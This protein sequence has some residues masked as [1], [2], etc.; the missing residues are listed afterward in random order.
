M[1]PED[2]VANDVRDIGGDGVV[3]IQQ[4]N[5]DVHE[6]RKEEQALIKH[7]CAGVLDEQ[8]QDALYKAATELAKKLAQRRWN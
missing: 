7:H 1:I 3:V 6:K 2:N 4:L 8:I 5:E